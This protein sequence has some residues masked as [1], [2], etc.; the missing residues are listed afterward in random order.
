MSRKNLG[1]DLAWGAK[2]GA[3]LAVVFCA[4]LGVAITV[5]GRAAYGDRSFL[6]LVAVTIGFGVLGGLSVGLV[7]PFTRRRWSA[8]IIG[9]L[10]G[11]VSAAFCFVL[12]FGITDLREM[13]PSVAITLLLASIIVGLRTAAMMRG[14]ESNSHGA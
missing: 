13:K 1:S 9:F 8:L 4:V 6:R 7:R 12:I 10:G 5:R 2:R 3:L 11:A 14:D